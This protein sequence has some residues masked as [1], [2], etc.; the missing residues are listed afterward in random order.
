[1]PYPCLSC[2]ERRPFCLTRL[3]TGHIRKKLWLHPDQ[4]K[5]MNC[6]EILIHRGF[7]WIEQV[8]TDLFC[9]E[10]I[11]HDSFFTCTPQN[12]CRK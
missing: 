9:L 5:S 8:Q 10:S 12:K 7:R 11:D 3:S 2:D 4:V 1:M 6:S